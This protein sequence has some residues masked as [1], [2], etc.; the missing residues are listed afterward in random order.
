M[1]QAKK[2]KQNN[3]AKEVL[4]D[5]NNRVYRVV[6]IAK[7]DFT[8]LKM[9]ALENSTTLYDLT[10]AKLAEVIQK[11]KS[12]L[13]AEFNNKSTIQKSLAINKAIFNKVKKYAI[14]NDVSVRLLILNALQLIIKNNA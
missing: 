7:D 5:S 1:L 9:Y 10:N 12:E 13:I 14:D 11:D 8:K 3:F 4:K 6:N 2:D